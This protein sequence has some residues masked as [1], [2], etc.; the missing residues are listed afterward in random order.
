MSTLASSQVRW[1]VTSQVKMNRQLLFGIM[2]YT[3]ISKHEF[4]SEFW[5]C[6]LVFCSH[7][8]YYAI[9]ALCD[10]FQ[11]SLCIQR[12]WIAVSTNKFIWG[13][14]YQHQ[15]IPGM[16]LQWYKNVMTLFHW[17]TIT[18]MYYFKMC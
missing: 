17:F 9:K 13:T 3:A 16:M 8:L 2:H 11:C 1:Q 5:N 7:L 6:P 10:I 18:Y 12:M 15:K 14:N 4:L